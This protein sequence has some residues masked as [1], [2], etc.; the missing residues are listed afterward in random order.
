M[1]RFR[2]G[3]FGNTGFGTLGDLGNTLS[4]I[5]ICRHGRC[6]RTAD[7]AQFGPFGLDDPLGGVWHR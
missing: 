6:Q 3:G 7:R 1:A 5:G 4:Q 2:S